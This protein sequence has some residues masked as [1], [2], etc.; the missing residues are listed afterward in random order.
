MSDLVALKA[1]PIPDDVRAALERH[2]V[3]SESREPR[4]SLRRG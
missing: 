4:D 3:A 2:L 1:I